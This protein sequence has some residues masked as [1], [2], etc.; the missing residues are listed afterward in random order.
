MI[1]EVCPICGSKEIVCLDKSAKKYRCCSCDDTFVLEEKPK[2][3]ER[4]IE[5]KDNKN[6]LTAAEIYKTV[7]GS[8]CEITSEF[9]NG[10]SQGTGFYISD[11]GYLITNCHVVI[12]RK[13]NGKYELC[14]E[15]YSCKSKS[16]DYDELEVVYIDPKNDLALLKGNTKSVKPLKL[17]DRLP[18]IGETVV[19]IGNSKGEGL[20]LVNGVVSDV[21]RDFQGHPAFLFNALVAHGCS[22]G[23]IFN[24]KGEV[25]GVTVGGRDDAEGMKYGI[26]IETLRKF[27]KTAEAE[28]NLTILL[29]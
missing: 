9:N 3:A 20:A 6:V 23:P 25:C 13:A 28:K 11:N 5:N 27:I 24:A 2:V 4:I 15:L 17:A 7:I 8:I 19:A 26:P 1:K 12:D 29:I 14:D 16:V 21:N 18:E 22:G 10:S